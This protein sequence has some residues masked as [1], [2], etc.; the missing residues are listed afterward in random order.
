MPDS[1]VGPWRKFRMLFSDASSPYHAALCMRLNHP[2]NTYVLN[3]NVAKNNTHSMIAHSV[4]ISKTTGRLQFVNDRSSPGTN[5]LLRQSEAAPRST[6][7]VE[8]S[9]IDRFLK[10]NGEPDV[11]FLKKL[12]LRDLK[13]MLCAVQRSPWMNR[14]CRAGLIELCPGNL[15]RVG[16]SVGDL[17]DAVE[18]CGWRLQFLNQDGSLGSVIDVHSA[19]KTALTNVA[20]LSVDSVP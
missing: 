2:R 15:R 20:L 12:T 1:E 14:R 19:E 9:T 18:Q 4:A 16:S 17:L 8:I 3:E 6:I 10:L 7:E 13:L 11:A 5:R